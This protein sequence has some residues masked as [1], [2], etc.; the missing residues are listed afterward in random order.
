M[1][2]D[3]LLTHGYR[4]YEDAHELAVMKPY[5]PLGLLYISSHLKAQGFAVDVFDTTFARRPRF[6]RRLDELRPPVVGIYANLMTRRER[7]RPHR[8]CAAA[9]GCVRRPGRARSREPRGASTSRTAPTSIVI[10]EGEIT[11]EELA[12]R[13]ARRGAQRLGRR[14]TASSSGTPTAGSCAPRRAPD[15]RPGRPAVPRPRSDRPAPATSTPGASTTVGGPSR[16]SPRAAVRTRAPGAATRSSATPTAAAHRRMSRTR[17]SASVAALP[18]GHAVVRRRRVHDPPDVADA[19]R[20]RARSAAASA[21]RSRPSAARTASTRR[22]WRRSRAWAASGSGSAPSRGSQRVLDAM[23]RRT[24]AARVPDVVHQ[25][26]AARHRGRHVHHAR[27]RRRGGRR[28][29]ADGRAAEA[30]PTRTC[31]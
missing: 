1:T 20:R 31:S 4:L 28:P 12:A 25:L 6:E 29:R 3:L 11:L 2:V 10:G 17:S 26:Q 23:Q 5:P 18:P 22:S 30:R 24:D 15:P 21:S 16:S 13:A 19:L 14:S 7:A 9:R 27:L 8:R